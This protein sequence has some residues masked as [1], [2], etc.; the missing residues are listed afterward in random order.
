MKRYLLPYLSFLFISSISFGAERYWIGG[1][2]SWHDP[3]HWSSVSGGPGGASVPGKGDDVHFDAASFASGGQVVIIEKDAA[4][5]YLSFG[6]LDYTATLA[7][8]LHAQLSIYGSLELSSKLILGLQGPVHFRSASKG[9]TILS[10]GAVFFCDIYFEHPSGSWEIKDDFYAYGNVVLKEGS[11]KVSARR[12]SVDRFTASGAKLR[13]LSFNETLIEVRKGWNCAETLNMIFDAGKSSMVFTSK[14]ADENYQPG[15]L[16]YGPVNLF[17]NCTP[18]GIPCAFFTINLTA[19]NVTCNG[20]SNGTA[21][22]TIVGGTGPFTYLWNP[23][24]QTTP[25]ATG[26]S[27]GTYLVTVTDGNGNVCFCQIAV[28]EPPALVGFPFG[29]TNPLCNGQCTGTATVSQVGGTGPYTYSWSTVPVQTT[30][31]ATGLCAGTYTCVITDANGCSP[32]S[33]T[34]VMTINQPAAIVNNGNSTNVTCFG[35]CDGTASVSPTGGTVPYDYSWTPGGATTSSISNLCPGTYTCTITDANGCTNQYVTTITQPAAPLTTTVSTTGNPVPCNGNCTAT[36]TA[37]PAGGTPGYTYNWAPGGQTTQTATGLC[38]GTYTVTVTDANGCTVQQTVTITQPNLLTVGISTTN[39][40]LACFNV[41]NATATATPNGGTAPYTY[42]WA[43]G[44]QSTPNITGLCAGSYTV[45]ITDVNGC[46]TNQSV[47]V[48]QPQQLT[49]TVSSTNNPLPCFGNCNA[50]ATANPSGGTSPYTYS[51]AT[52]PTSSAVTISNLCAGTYTV[53]VTDANGCT[54]SQSVTITQPP[55]MNANITTTNNPLL[56]NGDCN[57]TATSNPSGGTPGYTYSWAPGGQTTQTATGLC[58]GTYTLTITDAAGCTRTQTVT[59]TQPNALSLVA[60]PA[61][62]TLPCFGN[63]NASISANVAGGTAPYTYSWSTTPV[64]TTAVATGLCAG[65]YNVTV[66]DANGCTRVQS[67][68]IFQPTQLTLNALANPVSCFGACNGSASAIAG[69]GTPG[70]SYSWAPGGLT[71]S[72]INNQCAGTYTVT[73]TDANGCTGQQTVT[74]GTPPQLFTSVSWTNVLCNGQCNGTATVVA[75]GGTPPYTYN[76]TPGNM[77]TASISNLCPGTYTITVTDANGCTQQATVTITQPPLL[78]ASISATTTSCN[79][80]NGTATVTVAGGTP[81]YSYSWVTTPVQTTQT[82]VGLCPGQY[83]VVVTDANGC[84]ATAV[85]TVTQTVVITITTSG[86]TLNCFGD[87]NGIACA[88]PSGGQGPYSYLWSSTPFQTTQCATGLPA[89]T[90]TVNVTDANGCTGLDSVTFT[91]PPLLVGSVNSTNLSCNNTCDGTASASAVGGTGSY[92]Y[93]WMP[94]GQTTQNISGLCA[95]TYSVIITDINGC[96]DTVSVTITQAAALAANPVVSNANCTLCDGGITL[97]PTGGVPPYTYSWWNNGA[98]TPSITNLC[99]NIYTVTITDNA[100]C[101][102]VFT[103]AVSNIN[104][105]TVTTTQSN[106]LCNNDCN[107]TATANASGGTPPYTYSWTTTPA[108]L[109][110]TAT[111]LCAGTYTVQVTDAPG[112]VTFD[113]ITITEPLPVSPNATVVNSLCAANCNGSITLAPSGGTPG[114]SYAW[115]PNG[116][117]TSFIDSLCAGNYTVTVTDANGCDTTAVFTITAPSILSATVSGTNVNC[118]SA[119]DGQATASVMGGTAPYTYSWSCTP[120]ILPNVVNLCPGT[121]TVFVT[122]ANGCLDTAS[123]TITE[124]TL[125]TAASSQVDATCFNACNGTATATP[126]GGTPPYSYQWNTL[127]I[128]VTQTA[129][130]LCAGTFNCTVTDANGCT[131][132]IAVTINQ[133]SAVQPNPTQVN[134]SCFGSCNGSATSNPLGGTGPFTYSWTTLPAQ[135]TQS[136]TGLC[137]GTYTVFVTD[138]NGCTGSQTVTITQPNALQPNPSVSQSPTCPGSCD[139]ATIALP[140]GG[141][142]PYSYSWALGGQTT[143]NATGLCTGIY[144]VY[145]TDANGCTA[146]QTVN[147]TDPAAFVNNPAVAQANCGFCNGSITANITGGTPGYIYSW[148]PGGATTQTISNLCAG[149]YTLIVTD[150]NGCTQQ[151]TVPLSNTTGPVLTMSSTGTSCNTSPCDGTAS[152][153]ASGNS[154]FVYTWSPTGGTN[155]TA[156][157]LCYGS[158]TVQVTD[159]GNCITFDTITVPQP[160]PIVD[161]A[162]VQ[163][164]QCN[165]ICDGSITLAPTGSNGGPYTYSWFPGGMTTATVNNLCT[166]TYTVI[167]S[168]V[169]GCT[170]AFTYTILGTTVI[171]VASS[172]TNITCNNSC[173]GTATVT[174]VSGGLLP[175]TYLWNDPFGQFTPTATGLC[176]GTFIITVTDANGCQA[177]DTVT[178]TQSPAITASFTITQPS[179]GQCN[180]QIVATPSGGTA[181]YDIVWNTG[182]TTFTISGVCAG[183]YSAVITDANGCT[184]TVTVP[185]SNAGAPSVSVVTTNPVCFGSCT[186]TAT[187]TPSGGTPPYSFSWLPGGQ[188]TSAVNNLCAGTYY[189]Q[190]IDAN[191][192]IATDSVVITNPPQIVTNQVVVN[193]DCGIC[194][195]SITV[196]PSGGTAPYTYAWLPGGQTTPAINNLCAGVYTVTITDANGCSQ[197]YTIPITN[198]NAPAVTVSTTNV[199][200]NTACN[201]TAAANVTGGTPPYTY[202][203]ST[204]ASTPSLNGLCAGNYWVMVTDA[205]GCTTSVTFAVTQPPAIAFSQAVINDPLCNGDCNGSITVIPSGGT[206][207]F[208][209]N[210]STG[211]STPGVSGLCAGTYTVTVTDANGCTAQQIITLTDPPAITLSN[212]VT[213]SSCNTVPDGSI[214]I[215]V[216]GGSAPYTYSWSNGATTQDLTNVLSGTYTV[217]ITDA[218]NCSVSDTITLNATVS[219]IANILGNDTL[220]SGA[221]TVLDGSGSSGALSYQ[222]FEIPSMISLGTNDSITVCPPVGSTGYILITSNGA[223][224][225]TDTIVVV[226]NNL[227]V[228]DAGNDTTVLIYN[229]ATLGGVPTG[230]PGSTYSW[231]PNFALNDSTQ[232]NPVATPTTTT[233]YYVLVTSAQGCTALDS[234][235]ITVIPEINFPNGISPNGDGQNEYWIIDNI[236]LFPNNHVEIYNRWGEML[237]SVDGYDNANVKWDGTYKGQPLPVGTY[238]YIIDLKDELYPEAFTGPITILR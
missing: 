184:A 9:N 31:T 213:P 41:C 14:E 81:A 55:Q 64:Q 73:V 66:T 118:N 102:S 97:A 224:S 85:A 72:T 110:Q 108:Q 138:V 175:Y 70:Y 157:G 83:T 203:W 159:A 226:V 7:S 49:V 101:S 62:A 65:T 214:D 10:S 127:P 6:K 235:T 105:P 24:G 194:N 126:N 37:N 236:Q 218:N 189:V 178:I 52:T 79:V 193:T 171:N 145:V 135:L 207:P 143:Q 26:L 129:T 71:T 54:N 19:T 77:T 11:L 228:A 210:W 38:A 234:V 204:G 190:V 150:A 152:V 125:L 53:F 154:P 133:P 122:D 186:G 168:D 237:Y 148:L 8:A 32:P 176:A 153:V 166:G 208:S 217:I 199:L 177:F 90:Y 74:I 205:N 187:A 94:G 121:C 87:N 115:L 36:A 27:P 188:T 120:Q 137:A 223:C 162:V 158:Y 12:F 182:D 20:Q 181:P 48:T 179:C 15:N 91:N 163:N 93:S 56:C 146:S 4:C 113:S 198:I 169:N 140:I 206:L 222:W 99:P 3:A 86:T 80:C 170:S 183:V 68:T 147:L 75:N 59:I 196:N 114:Y 219:V 39:N 28:T 100:G 160:S 82:A 180:G 174:N 40:P 128:Q 44:G 220:C 136:A 195:G 119:C 35:F 30:P 46:T 2:G 84:T 229:S 16:R 57:A 151:F 92:S 60:T 103:I 161:N 172:S 149:L 29:S 109:T 230:P 76:W 139:G 144:T 124:P 18:A 88:T 23:S 209:Y 22:A 192:C 104:G 233:T 215:T 142:A 45:Y 50:T 34:I 225:D 5:R 42:S 216:G 173:V 200:C 156:T 69:G 21:T 106:A 238:Y 165:G 61:P 112:C 116:E 78:T 47:T 167:I 197:T 212:T 131:V 25:T 117:T 96:D 107:G 58:A 95:G 51:W 164:A 232:A 43:P 98:T 185:V 201:G 1:S 13:A 89:G 63:C 221:C 130:G 202:S 132:T 227:P 191:G 134:A 211:A 33:A 141:T 231:Y 111:G 123:V 17:A 67:V 155:A